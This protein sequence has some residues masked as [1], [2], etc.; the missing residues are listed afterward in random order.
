[1]TRK[2]KNNRGISLI[3]LLVVVVVFAFVGIVVTRSIILTLEGTQK[4]T[5]TVRSRENLDYAMSIIE[6][7][8]RNAN[9][10]ADC[11]NSNTNAISYFDQNG[12]ASSFSCVNTGSPNSYVASGSATLTDNTVEII[13]CS[14]TCSVSGSNPPVIAVNLTI[15]DVSNTVSG[16]GSA[17]ATTQIDLR[18][19]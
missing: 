4:S 18:N 11:S 13:N 7:Q 2:T 12:V 1:M 8:I 19:Y 10:I 5:S 15:K 16:E 6:R 9:S 14:F 3:E 17:Y